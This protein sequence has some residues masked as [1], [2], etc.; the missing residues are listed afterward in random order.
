MAGVAP[1]P[2]DRAIA[3]ILAGGLADWRDIT[4]TVTA[5]L[6]IETGR[7]WQ[8]APREPDPDPPVEDA[9]TPNHQ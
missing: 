3:R 7:T 8:G 4:D 6:T 1:E 9:T 5:P 2:A